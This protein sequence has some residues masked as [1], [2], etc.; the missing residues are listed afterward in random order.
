MLSL[1][2]VFICISKNL[3]IFPL[4]CCRYKKNLLFLVTFH[5]AIKTVVYFIPAN[6]KYTRT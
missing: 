4:K 3:T 6:K 2:I 1:R 5:V